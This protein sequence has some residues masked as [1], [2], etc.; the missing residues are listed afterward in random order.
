ML[1]LPMHAGAAPQRLLQAGTI[2]PLSLD[3]SLDSRKV[4]DGQPIRLEVMQ[5]IPHSPVKRRSHV[6]G[7]I[8]SVRRS[9]SGPAELTLRFDEIE[10][11]GKHV[12]L[13]A[14]LRALASWMEVEQA[15]VPEESMDRGITP[16]TATTAQI[17][18][19]Q[20]YRGGG[21]VA[22]GTEAVAIPTPYGALGSPRPN[23]ERGCRG[24]VGGDAPQALWLFS[25][26][27]C[28]VYG[29]PHLRIIH[30]G[31]TDPVGTIV[32]EED[33]GALKLQGGTG[34]LLRVQ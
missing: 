17:G 34:M 20:V 24:E 3:R 31:K 5:D 10:A 25:T 28:G 29:V 7:Y 22:S 27:A 2:L 26:D 15:K 30:T 13:V 19:E 6:F 8:V 12:P 14:S 11:H 32:L 18:G 33:S 1:W 9:V 4:H 21:P 23:V 16:E